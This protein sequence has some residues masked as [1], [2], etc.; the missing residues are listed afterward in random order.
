MFSEKKQIKQFFVKSFSCLVLP[1]YMSNTSHIK[2][3]SYLMQKQK[4]A[5]YL[6]N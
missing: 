1:L 3:P 4:N 2:A 5:L 6:R